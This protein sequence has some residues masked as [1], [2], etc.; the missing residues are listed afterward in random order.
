MQPVIFEPPSIT[1]NTDQLL[2]ELRIK[3][4]SPMADDLREMV[5]QAEVAARPKVLY[6]LSLVELGGNNLVCLDGNTFTSRIL[7]VNLQAVHRVFPFVATCGREVDEWSTAY[8]EDMLQEFWADA[9]KAAVLFQGMQAFE[10]YLAQRYEPGALSSMNPG[11]LEDWPM[12]EQR[13]LF[14]LLGDV[15][16]RIGV[17]LTDSLLMVPTK[18][19]SGIFFP[20]ETGFASCQLCPRELCPNRRAPYDPDLFSQKYN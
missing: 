11:S 18:S 14:H 12:A 4:A 3:P 19:V 13:P 16:A 1:L 15:R 20:T 7:H 8:A 2:Q 6:T 5:R 9:I 10:Q 17:E